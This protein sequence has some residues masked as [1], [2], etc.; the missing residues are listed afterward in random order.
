M[1]GNPSPP[2]NVMPWPNPSPWPPAAVP[3]GCFSEL[4]RL[5]QCYNEVQMMEY[6]LTQVICDL[7]Q[8]SKQFQQCLANAVAAIGA[9]MPITGVTNGVAA[10]P[11]IV[12][13]FVQ[14]SNITI[15]YTAAE[16]TQS[17]TLGILQPGD[18]YCNAW[19]YFGPMT[20]INFYLNP[21]PTGFSS[22]MQGALWPTSTPP[23]AEN[24]LLVAPA[25]QALITVPTA[26]VFTATTN[27]SAT[28][29]AGTLQLFFTALRVR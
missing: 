24:G 5:N 26:I 22:N 28:G 14:L 13:E 23:A 11:G 7:S 27:V 20:G 9:G 3:P 17:I 18:W 1:S 19:A 2:T 6:I 29:T 10:Q 16:Q 25:A 4:A 21:T 12:G 15:P 8:N